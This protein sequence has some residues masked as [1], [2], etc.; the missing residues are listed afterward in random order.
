MI[1]DGQVR[2]LFRLLGMGATLA[3]AARKTDMDEK[4]AR[5]Y[6]RAGQ[7][8]SQRITPRWWRTR[9]DPFADV[10][11]LVEKR[12]EEDSS[13]QAITLFEWL[14]KHPDHQGKFPDSQRRTFERRVRRW[15]A[16][17]GP[18]QAVMF[19]QVHYPGDLAASDFTHMKAL[20]V[21]IHGQP[22]AHLVYHF[23]LTYSNWES[24]TVCP[25][26]SFE[27]L[28]EG[29]QNA[30]WELGGVPRRHR[31]DSLTAAV[32][33]LS[34]EREFRQRYQGLLGYYGLEG[35]R[36]NVGEAHENG[37][38]ESSHG[39][40]KTAVD[41][42]LR[43]RGSRDFASREEY[44]KFLGDLAARRNAGRQQRFAEEQAVLRDLPA[45]RLT[46]SRRLSDIRVGTGSTIQVLGNTYSV[47]SRLKGQKVEVVI[48]MEHVE[49][50]YAG[51]EVQRMPR[52]Y[53]SDKHAINY[54]HII[55]SLVRKPGA[56][57]NYRYREELFPT[58]H[59]RMAYDAL[60][61]QHAD[62]RAVRE[63]L[64]ILRLAAHESEAGVEAALRVALGRGEAISFAAVEAAVQSSQQVPVLTEVQVEAP[65]LQAFDSLLDHCYMEVECHEFSTQSETPVAVLGGET[66]VEVAC[67]ADSQATE[68]ALESPALGL[69]WAAD[70][71]GGVAG[72]APGT[73]LADVPRAL[74]EPG[75]ASGAGVAELPGVPGGAD[76]SGMPDAPA[77]ADPEVVGAIAAAPGE[78]LGE[79]RLEADSAVRGPSGGEPARGVVPGP[80][81]EPA[82]VWQAGLGQD[83]L[84]VCVGR[85]PGASGACDALHHH[86]PA[87]AELV[88]GEAGPAVAEGDQATVA[89]RGPDP[90]RPR[91]RA[92]QPRGD[93]GPVHA[94]G[95][96]LRAGER[97]ADQQPAVFAV[98]ANLQGCHDHGG[99]D[100]PLGASL[101]NLGVEHP[102]LPAGDRSAQSSI[103]F[104]T[105][106]TWTTG[107]MITAWTREF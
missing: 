64:K 3:R 81:G 44:E 51:Q 105:R 97:A 50:W 25:S 9:S 66:F 6:R 89:V 101:R 42:A 22:F 45:Q 54:R 29:L 14:Q 69:A 53:G 21:T 26:E 63:Y 13:L 103:S 1:K 47:H 102:Q 80:S 52:L 100:R 31:S 73:S 19:A 33:N 58:S 90:R 27:A 77:A 16:T 18:G 11:P 106:G 30:L 87:G 75:G 79:L 39:H 23:T 107:G 76:A 85:T 70:V 83:A 82:G 7:L 57:E 86:Q 62:K 68:R 17:Q 12:L 43:L 60:C 92:T 71:A 48:G 32:N 49:V 78:D 8:P 99:R 10:W 61:R 40:F 55:D 94:A 24:I 74:P 36:I 59:F 67:A 96:T 4:T 46:S 104:A 15:R 84:P 72:A 93:G 88:G 38:V 41:Q 98:G 28:S 34:E 2:N 5:K 20:N 65:D 91:L 95:R 56:F 35:Q 37:D